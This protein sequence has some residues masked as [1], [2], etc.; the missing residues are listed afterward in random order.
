M[1]SCSMNHRQNCVVSLDLNVKEPLLSRSKIGVKS[2]IST[3]ISLSD[4][5][6]S[7]LD[8]VFIYI[9]L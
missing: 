3:S 8:S 6:L 9:L 2:L 4:S 7:I 5:S 1:N